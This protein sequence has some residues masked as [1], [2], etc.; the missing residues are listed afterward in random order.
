MELYEVIQTVKYL[1]VE[2][3]SE[4]QNKVPN[5]GIFT[6][7]LLFFSEQIF[8]FFGFFAKMTLFFFNWSYFLP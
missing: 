3:D 5:F 1:P 8:N 4:N 2:T 6:Y 7:C